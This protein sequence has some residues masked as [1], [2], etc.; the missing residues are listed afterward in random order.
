MTK[1][2]KTPKGTEL[3]FLNLQGK[4]Y[5]QIVH[6]IVWFREQYPQWTIDTHPVQIDA[7]IAIMSASIK[8]ETGRV[9]SKA[10]G[11]QLAK[12]FPAYIEKAESKSVGRALGFLGFGTAHAQELED[13]DQKDLSTLAD[14]P[15]HNTSTKNSPAILNNDSHSPY[16]GSQSKK[17]PPASEKQIGFLRKLAG[18]DIELNKKANSIG[19][20]S[21]KELTIEDA[22]TLIDGY[23]KQQNFGDFR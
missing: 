15:L 23:Q 9:L 8:D 16:V 19:R 21:Y 10:H 6:R 18:S 17:I 5:L 3:P 14:S 7:T 12:S 1:T 13:E 11:A 2:F 4:D 20:S 22:K